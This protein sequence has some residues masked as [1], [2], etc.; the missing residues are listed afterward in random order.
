MAR[1][2][3]VWE[4]G[5]GMGHMDR[6]LITARALRDRGHEV[7][8][9]LRDLSRAHTRVSA[10][11]FMMMQTPVWLPQMANPP[12]LGNYAAVLASAGWLSP[13]GLAG[14]VVGWRSLFALNQP[15]LIICDHAPTAVLASRGSG[16]LTLAMGNS[17]E[18]PP[19]GDYF[20][21]MAYWVAGE[22]ALC[23]TYDSALLSSCNEALKILGDPP[24]GK[25]TDLF[26]HTHQA[27]ISMPEFNHYAGYRA[28]TPMLGPAYV[29]NIGV[30]PVWPV[31]MAKHERP[32]IFAYLAPTY[33]R[34]EP[35]MNAIKASGLASLIHAK[36]ISAQ[37]AARLGGPNMRFESSAVRMDEVLQQASIVVS[38]A[39]LGTVCA[40]ALAGKIQLGLPQHTEQE[41][42]SRRLSETGVGLAVSSH[43]QTTQVVDFVKL[44]QR[45]INEPSFAISAKALAEKSKEL[46]S[47]NT[48]GKAVE[49]IESFL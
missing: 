26:A 41:M 27:L 46:S 17:F 22:Q 25:L 44:L 6:M 35:L 31:D 3:M 37:A 24:L 29:D 16:I 39:S 4:M 45:L 38:H 15:D 12:R 14:L 43:L 33:S 34:F 8:M 7:R 19:L 30:A 21:A 5:S 28:D 32:K 49:W 18:L 48:G 42:V 47:N 23:A 40:A 1:V 13:V 20:P 9:A 36:G 10:D 11:G 2:L